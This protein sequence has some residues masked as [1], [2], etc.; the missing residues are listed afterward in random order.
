MIEFAIVLCIKNMKD[1]NSI[2]THP[3]GPLFD[4][5]I[6]LMELK[7][8]ESIGNGKS[9]TSKR[10]KLS[11]P[12]KIDYISLVIFMMSYVLY[13]SAYFIRLMNVHE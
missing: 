12:Q 7:S 10:E 13:S 4:G 8:T 9:R 11:T 3:K 2:K 6:D 1:L 5:K